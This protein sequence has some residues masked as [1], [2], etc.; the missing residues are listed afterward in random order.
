MTRF[1]ILSQPSLLPRST[2]QKFL[3]YDTLDYE[4]SIYVLIMTNCKV[5]YSWQSDLPNP[6]NRGFILKALEQATKSICKDDSIEV[7]PVVDRDTAN[8]P[9]SPDIAS[10]IFTKI[11][12][13]QVFVCDISIINSESELQR[14]TPNPNV[15]IELGYAFK[16]LGSERV[17]MV[18][19]TAFG[20]PEDLPFDLKMR[21]V[22]TYN[23][24]KEDN[25]KSQERNK[26]QLTLN[27]ALRSILKE[28]VVTNNF[29]NQLQDIVNEFSYDWDLVKSIE[30]IEEAK[31]RLGQCINKIKPIARTL[32]PQDRDDLTNC[33]KTMQSLTEYELFN[34]SKPEQEFW[35]EGD[36]IIT[37]L[38]QFTNVNRNQISDSL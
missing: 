26:L 30:S 28:E 25:D 22:I 38:Q 9:G 15:L 8:V 33:L 13:A 2:K 32:D 29:N 37:Y 31:Y 20:K 21:R 4:S 18:M 23:S 19:N 34:G 6:T 14:L 1:P 27:A 7:E 36:I 16:A 24:N 10:T 17:I 11:E 3:V 35:G 12:K 5:F